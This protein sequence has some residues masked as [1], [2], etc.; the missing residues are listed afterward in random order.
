MWA[1][2]HMS[3]TSSGH[4]LLTFISCIQTSIL[5]LFLLFFY[6]YFSLRS[7]EQYQEINIKFLSFYY[8]EKLKFSFYCFGSSWS[9]SLWGFILCPA[10]YQTAP[11]VSKTTVTT[12]KDKPT[13]TIKILWYQVLQLIGCTHR[14]VV[15]IETV[16]EK[17]NKLLVFL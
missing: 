2:C 6:L 11:I 8:I 7:L 10:V 16:F 14:R 4:F 17:V 5:L 12:K 15:R 13:T 1:L 9:T 3:P